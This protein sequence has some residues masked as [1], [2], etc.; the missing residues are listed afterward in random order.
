MT[1]SAGNEPLDNPSTPAYG[2]TACS[3]PLMIEGPAGRFRC[4]ARLRC[5]GGCRNH[6]EVRR[7]G[8][9]SGG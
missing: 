6:H 7:R 2:D 9:H 5:I 8:F 4:P 1:R 3:L